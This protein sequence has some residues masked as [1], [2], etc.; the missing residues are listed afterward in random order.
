[1]KNKTS[2]SRTAANKRWANKNKEKVKQISK[3]Y[4]D[5]HKKER[6]KYEKQDRDKHP[7]KYQKLRKEIYNRNY[8]NFV[9]DF[10]RRRRR[11]FNSIKHRAKKRN[12]PFNI[13]LDDIIIPEKCPVLGTPLR[14]TELNQAMT[15]RENTPSV[16]RIVPSLGY[17]KGNITV[18][19]HKANRIKADASIDEVRKLLQW[20]EMLQPFIP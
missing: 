8:P 4:R 10:E 9:L 6:R 5:T 15:H 16:D 13:T 20:M 2:K 1:M 11:L 7:L 3:H 19:S 14:F 17:T 18:I 12:I